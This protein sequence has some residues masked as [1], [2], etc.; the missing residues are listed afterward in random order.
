MEFSVKSSR[1]NFDMSWHLCEYAILFLMG[2]GGPSSCS[3]NPKTTFNSFFR[4]DSI[5]IYALYFLPF[6]MLVNFGQ[7]FVLMTFVC[8]Q[9]VLPFVDISTLLYNHNPV[10]NFSFP[11]NVQVPFLMWRCSISNFSRYFIRT[12][13]FFIEIPSTTL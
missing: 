2:W 9:T 3:C 12:S 1:S 4:N 13:Y 5:I 11:N 7:L 6:K 10:G 8:C